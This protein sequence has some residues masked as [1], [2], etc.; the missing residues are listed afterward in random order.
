VVTNVNAIGYI[1]L[2][3]MSNKVNALGIAT[4]AGKPFVEPAVA[5]VKNKTYPV[6]RPLYWYTNGK[7]KGNV[8]KLVDFALSAEGQKVVAELDFVPVK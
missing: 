8:K 1:G 7:P 5:T 6:S 4:A 2:G 3:Y